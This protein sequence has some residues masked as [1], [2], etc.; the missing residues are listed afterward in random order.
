MFKIRSSSETDNQEMF[1]SWLFS[2]TDNQNMFWTRLFSET[3]KCRTGTQASSG[4]RQIKRHVER[5]WANLG[6]EKF[7]M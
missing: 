7:T 3:D 1:R 5:T 2:E 6:T 4:K